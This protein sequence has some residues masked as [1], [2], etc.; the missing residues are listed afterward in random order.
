MRKSAQY[1]QSPITEKYKL[2]PQWDITSLWLENYQRAK[3][4]QIF[5]MIWRE[6]EMYTISVGM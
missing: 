3:R 6:G 1:H 5:V 2:K 4:R